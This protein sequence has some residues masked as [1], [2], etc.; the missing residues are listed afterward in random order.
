[1]NDILLNYIKNSTDPMANFDLAYWYEKQN[2]LSPASSLYL[3]CAD[4]TDDIELRYQ[5]LIRCFICYDIIGK[6]D[7]TCKTLLN[8]ALTTYPTRPEAY[9]LLSQFYS[10]RQDFLNAYTFSSLALSLVNFNLQPLPNT[11]YRGKTDF[12]FEKANSAWHIGKAQEAK[13][14]YRFIFDRLF[15]S[16]DDSYKS[17]LENNLKFIGFSFTDLI[18]SD[19]IKL[20]SNLGLN[21]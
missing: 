5:S 19:K 8:Q 6:R 2:H 3:R 14:L 10:W 4:F 15:D 11:K 9:Y 18:S 16:L 21:I 12:Y 20:I 1:M 7:H 13:D 17:V